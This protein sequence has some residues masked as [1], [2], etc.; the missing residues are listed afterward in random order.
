MTEFQ[1]EYIEVSYIPVV[2]W[3]ITGTL[4]LFVYSNMRERE[5]AHERENNGHVKRV[6]KVQEQLTWDKIFFLFG[7][8]FQFYHFSPES[9]FKK[10]KY[11]VV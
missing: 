11:G 3:C 9:F 1:F 10:D 6:M 2:H 4:A 7:L 8:L 5:S